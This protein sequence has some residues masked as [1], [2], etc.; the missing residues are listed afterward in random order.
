MLLSS[1]IPQALSPGR[2]IIGA[3][4]VLVSA[5]ACDLFTSPG[6]DQTGVTVRWKFSG[7]GAS[8]ELYADSALVV[9]Y[10][11][12]G[13]SVWAVDAATGSLR[14]HRDFP[15]SPLVPPGIL[16][17]RA[18][19]AAGS[20][21]VIPGWDLYGLDRATG[22]ILWTLRNDDLPGYETVLAD[23]AVFSA[24]IGRVYRV[25]PTSGVVAWQTQ[26]GEWS[27]TIVERPF[28]PVYGDGV[29]YVVTTVLGIGAYTVPLGRR[30]G[31]VVALSATSGATLWRFEIPEAPPFNGGAVDPGT[32][33]GDVF[34]VGTDNGR[35]Y[36]V[37]RTTGSLRWV[38]Q[39]SQRYEAGVVIV[40]GGAIT[41]NMDG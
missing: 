31:H 15:I 19:V 7:A 36:G 17:M 40:N 38:H 18:P 28:A 23:G 33:A 29:V 35:V 37:D 41:A 26:V 3:L 12:S 4:F 16:P 14:W 6:N 2:R 21:L 32:I 1:G 9:F 27:D 24:G 30:I 25:D 13:T 20:V 11:L 39:G 10:P 22:T 34:I 8:G 5:A